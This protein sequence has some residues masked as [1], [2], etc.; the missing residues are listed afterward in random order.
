MHTDITGNR[1]NCVSCAAE[2]KQLFCTEGQCEDL[3]KH[4][5]EACKQTF[6]YKHLD[7]E[8]LKYCL[9][10]GENLWLE[11][12]MASDKVMELAREIA[13]FLNVTMCEEEAD[14]FDEFLASRLEPIVEA[15]QAIL[16]PIPE[17]EHKFIGYDL[18]HEN[19]REGECKPCGEIRDAQWGKLR[20]ALHPSRE[21][22]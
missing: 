21:E 2:E 3:G 17:H 4:L 7:Q 13:R 18:P 19:W 14:K 20:T 15:A 6:C 11:A 16:D 9:V 1:L 8:L 12:A 10:C 22:K 5:C